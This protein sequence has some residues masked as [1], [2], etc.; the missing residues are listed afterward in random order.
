EGPFPAMTAWPALCDSLFRASPT[1]PRSF[2]TARL[3]ERARDRDAA[4]ERALYERHARAIHC[5]A[6]DLVGDR[7]DAGDVVQ[8]TFTRAFRLLSTLADPDHY[9]PWLYGIARNVGLECLKRRRRWRRL[10]DEA[11]HV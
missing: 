4:A 7:A 2:P 1:E 11:E 6:L 3:V 5:F 10:C 9:V 8:E